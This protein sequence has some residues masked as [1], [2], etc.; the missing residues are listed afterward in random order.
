[1][2]IGEITII[3]VHTIFIVAF[4]ALKTEDVPREYAGLAF[5]STLI[6]TAVLLFY[7]F[8]LLDN[9]NTQIF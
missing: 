4:I 8:V 2:T 6:T 9:W 7:V 3:L 5:A 1:M